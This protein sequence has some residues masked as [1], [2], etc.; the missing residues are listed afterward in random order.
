MADK[1]AFIK[2]EDKRVDS[3]KLSE[4]SGGIRA[5]ISVFPGHLAL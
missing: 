3:D 4:V 5:R 2:D 1:D